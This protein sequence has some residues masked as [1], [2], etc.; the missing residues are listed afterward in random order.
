MLLYNCS[1]GTE[2]KTKTCVVA[3]SDRK[4]NVIMKKY[5]TKCGKPFEATG[6]EVICPACKA[7]AAEESKRA[8][9]LRAKKASWTGES[10]PVRIS[11]RASTL[12]REFSKAHDVPFAEALDELLKSTSFFVNLGVEWLTIQPYKS[13]RRDKHATEPQQDTASKPQDTASKPQE[14]KQDAPQEVKTAAKKAVKTITSKVVKTS[15]SKAAKTEKGGVKHH[16][17]VK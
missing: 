16:A 7:Q 6:R 17:E 2:K 11:G 13:H 5:C 3:R 12:I 10:V 9:V 1:E 14:A 8:A 4:E 15:T